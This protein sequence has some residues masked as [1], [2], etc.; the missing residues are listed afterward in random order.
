MILLPFEPIALCMYLQLSSAVLLPLTR[1]TNYNR[2]ISLVATTYGNQYDVE[3]EIGNQTYLLQLDTGSA[4]IWVIVQDF[5]CLNK[6]T[7]EPEDQSI[8]TYGFPRW[9]QS[10]TFRTIPNEVFAVQYGA[11]NVIGTMGYDTVSMGGIQMQNQTIGIGNM[12]FN[13]GDGLSA[14]IFGLGF[15]WDTSAHPANFNYT[16]TSFLEEKILYK[17]FLLN[18]V[19]LGLIAD[20]YFSIAI[21]RV[22]WNRSVSKTG[23]YLGLGAIP[24][25]P[26]SSNFVATPNEVN[27]GIPLVLTDGKPV[28]TLWTLTVQSTITSGRSNTTS[29]QACPDTGNNFNLYPMEQAAAINAQFLPPGKIISEDS[30]QFTFSVDC[31]STPPV[32]GIT[33]GNQTFYIDPRDMIIQVNDSCV[34]AIAGQTES[35]V[36]IYFLGDVFFKNVVAVFDFGKNEM[37]FSS[38]TNGS[39]CIPS[40]SS[41]IAFDLIIV[42]FLAFSVWMVALIL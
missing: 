7:L 15:P 19:D 20:P 14:G 13:H 24:A 10:P 42:Y 12:S 22:P 2:C 6:D 25:V 28:L 40:G 9:H 1:R 8:C 37:R 33:I 31:N 35:E 16:N 23:G 27:D 17:P 26:H 30:D 39:F 5:I 11:G 3:V 36:V 38:R 21:D 18:A 4:D 29:F 41:S 32:H 34:S